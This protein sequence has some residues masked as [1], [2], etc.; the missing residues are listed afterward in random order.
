MSLQLSSKQSVGDVW[1]AQLDRGKEFHKRGPAA[2]EV[3]SKAIAAVCSR[4]QFP[5][6]CIQQKSTQFAYLSLAPYT[7]LS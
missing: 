2:V 6:R 3:L 1:I 7:I 4:M 5:D